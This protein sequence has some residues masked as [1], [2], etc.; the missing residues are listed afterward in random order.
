MATSH[1]ICPNASCAMASTRKMLSSLSRP[2]MPTRC[3]TSSRWA[4]LHRSRAKSPCERK[5]A[6]H[7]VWGLAYIQSIQTSTGP[8]ASFLSHCNTP[9]YPLH[10]TARRFRAPT[11]LA[12]SP[13]RRTTAGCYSWRCRARR[14]LLFSRTCGWTSPR[15]AF[16]DTF[17]GP[18]PFLFFRRPLHF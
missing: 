10:T 8:C 9:S 15:W 18:L 14:C 16:A 7:L 3:F 12:V 4:F 17:G 13:V 5:E 11:S 1:S 2:F 6:A